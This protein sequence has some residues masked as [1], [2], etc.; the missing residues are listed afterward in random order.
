MAVDRVIRHW[1]NKAFR[2]AATLG[3]VPGATPAEMARSL[4]E[5]AHLDHDVRPFAEHAYYEGHFRRL[6]R[7]Q[8][9]NFGAGPI[10]DM[11]NVT[12]GSH[13]DSVQTLLGGYH[14]HADYPNLPSPGADL[15]VREKADLKPVREVRE[16]IAKTDS[17]ISEGSTRRRALEDAGVKFPEKKKPPEPEEATVELANKDAAAKKGGAAEAKKDED[18]DKKKKDKAASAGATAA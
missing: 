2:D 5:I 10:A 6:Y 16:K 18:K 8:L 17:R 7:D 9:R 13:H 14:R 15:A 12:M 3:G 1:E 4:A 11:L